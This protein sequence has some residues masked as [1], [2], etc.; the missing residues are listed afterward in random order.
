MAV[1]VGLGGV[2]CFAKVGFILVEP[3]LRG[4][5]MLRDGHVGHGYFNG[6]VEVLE[7]G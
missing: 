7:L 6:G 4:E 3:C 2:V 5:R 1:V